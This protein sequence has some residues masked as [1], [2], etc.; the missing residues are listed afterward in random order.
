MAGHIRDIAI[1]TLVAFAIL[2]TGELA[3]R[4]RAIVNGQAL[5]AALTQQ[6]RSAT[7]FKHP[8][9]EYTAA[10]NY[11]GMTRLSQ[12]PT[13]LFYVRTN[14]EGF[15]THEFYPKLPGK[16]RVVLLGDSFTMGNNANQSETYASVLESLLQKKV[17]P[18]VEVFSLA[19]G[20]YSAVRYAALARMYFDLLRP[21]MVIVAVDQSDFAEDVDRIGAYELDAGGIP[22]V[23]RKY[24]EYLDSQNEPDR[25]DVV[26]YMDAAR[27]LRLTERKASVVD[28]LRAGSLLI[29][30]ILG[31][32]DQL[33]DRRD[34]ESWIRKKDES[35][36]HP[37]SAPI[38]SY[39][40][41]VAQAKDGDFGELLPP[42]LRGDVIPVTLDRAKKLYE[43]TFRCLKFIRDEARARGAQVYFSSYPYP[44][45]VSIKEAVPFQLKNFGAIYDLRKDRVHPD[46]MA[47][48][49][50]QL[51]VPHLDAY[52][53]FERDPDGKYGELDQH[54]NAA[55][56]ATY[57]R[58]LYDSI[59]EQ[60][61]RELAGSGR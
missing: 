13:Q 37:E 5:S 54:M 61:A 36:R 31:W 3:L 41:L 1:S 42:V 35:L 57:A 55:G 9:L 60:I 52:P 32:T 23:L 11:R 17:S 43:P 51:E 53:V 10:T 14:S 56:Y 19:V 58:F 18:D 8:F 59:H 46:L 44:Y 28:H 20:S 7:R 34:R 29:D 21:D 24:R 45:M 40:D 6:Q 33:R 12:D 16:Y 30:A 39:D 22:L 15:R 49:S 26:Q 50:A 25:T 27:K 2:L 48:F 4:I 38:K 47:Y